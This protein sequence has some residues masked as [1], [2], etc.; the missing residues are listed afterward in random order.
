MGGFAVARHNL[1]CSKW[2]AGNWDRALKHFMIAAGDGYSGSV[3]CIQQMYRDGH[4]TKEDYTKA[5]LA[6]QKYLEEIRSDQRDKS[7]A[8]SDEFKCY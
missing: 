8:F 4:A 3:K 2:R 6:Y 7:A 1:G 5:L